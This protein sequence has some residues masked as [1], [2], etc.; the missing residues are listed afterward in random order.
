MGSPASEAGPVSTLRVLFEDAD[1]VAVDK[2]SGLHTAPLRQGEGGT[3]LDLVIARFPE[4]ARV[5][6]VKPVEPGL[7]HRLDRETSGVVLVARTASAFRGLLAL[8]RAG[9][10]RKEYLALCVPAAAVAPGERLRAASRFAPSGPGRRRVRVVPVGGKARGATAAA[11]ATEAEVLQVREGKA[12]VRAVIVRGFRHQV[13]AH[14]AFLGLP[15]A[16]D[17][18]YGAPASA[19]PARLFLHASILSFRHPVSGRAMRFE[20]PLPPEFGDFVSA[21]G[22]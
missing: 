18:L 20:A 11:Y 4:V 2:P 6:G 17:P 9:A 16:G 3:L 1:L 19:S 15:I 10:V 13:R 8:F 21:P 12:L 14:L 22:R 7:L 5:P